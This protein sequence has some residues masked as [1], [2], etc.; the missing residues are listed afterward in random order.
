MFLVNT[1][2]RNKDKTFG[3]E[4]MPKGRY[5]VYEFKK[6]S[7]G[8]EAKEGA[9]ED[10]LMDRETLLLMPGFN[11]ILKTLRRRIWC[12]VKLN[13]PGPGPVPEMNR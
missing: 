2:K 12:L 13:L 11:N 7:E 1:R 3:H 8:K 5:A 6:A 4:R 9:L 10:I